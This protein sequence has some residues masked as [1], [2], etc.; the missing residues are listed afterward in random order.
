MNQKPLSVS[1]SEG[2]SSYSPYFTSLFVQTADPVSL[3]Q[4]GRGWTGPGPGLRTAPVLRKPRSPPSKLT[5]A[6]P[7][8]N[9]L[10]ASPGC[11]LSLTAV[12]FGA[13]AFVQSCLQNA[14]SGFY[15][16]TSELII[17]VCLTPGGRITRATAAISWT[18]ATITPRGSS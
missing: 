2:P 17:G 13:A 15:L 10:Q 7:A 16:F 12:W 8:Y 4:T 11:T 3:S 18:F 6:P 14:P 9:P 1:L 5:H